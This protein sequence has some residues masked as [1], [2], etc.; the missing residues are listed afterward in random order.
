MKVRRVV[1]KQEHCVV[2]PCRAGH[3][4]VRVKVKRVVIKQEHCV[5]FLA[6]LGTNATVLYV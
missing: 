3:S 2:F 5:F 6:E 4:A 1:I